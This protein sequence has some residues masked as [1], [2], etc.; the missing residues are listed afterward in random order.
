ME[1]EIDEKQDHYFREYF[2]FACILRAEV[3][4]LEDIK[5]LILRDYVSIKNVRLIKPTYAKE[6]LRMVGEADWKAFQDFLKRRP[7]LREG[8]LDE[9]EYFNFAFI[10][11]GYVK[12]LEDIKERIL[13]NYV[14]E[15][16][17]E[18]VKSLY[19]K[20]KIYIINESEW[21][22]FEKHGKGGIFNR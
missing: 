16:T 18:V 15:G 12:D 7:L 21:K 9:T 19:S 2:N 8:G 1:D 5:E 3:K 13:S 11:R 4:Y 17:V 20:S 10:V 14:S 6:E 22:E